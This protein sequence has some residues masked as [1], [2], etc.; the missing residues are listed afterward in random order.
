MSFCCQGANRMNHTKKSTPWKIQLSGKQQHLFL[1]LI[2]FLMDLSWQRLRDCISWNY[3]TFQELLLKLYY[4]LQNFFF[5]HLT[6]E[7]LVSI[8]R[9]TRNFISQFMPTRYLLQLSIIIQPVLF[10]LT[11]QHVQIRSEGL[12]WCWWSLIFRASP[13]TQSLEWWDSVGISGLGGR[14]HQEACLCKAFLV[15]RLWKRKNQNI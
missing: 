8:S 3:S 11:Q 13:I 9:L 1:L 6:Q 15:N 14:K 2:H 4:T 5:F 10:S 12:T 7:S